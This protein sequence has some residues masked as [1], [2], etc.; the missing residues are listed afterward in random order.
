MK[1]G[2]TIF[3]IGRPGIYCTGPEVSPSV[4]EPIDEMNGWCVRPL[5]KRSWGGDMG[6]IFVKAAGVGWEKF[7]SGEYLMH[8][9]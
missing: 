7:F 8:V 1:K 4:K 9:E 2:A 3:G 5:G 6:E